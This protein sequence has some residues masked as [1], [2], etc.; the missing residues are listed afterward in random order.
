MKKSL[1]FLFA[2]TI[3]MTT[4]FS[5]V[6]GG[7]KAGLN[8]AN[9]MSSEDGWDTDMMTG[10]HIGGYL[11]L[12]VSES[13]SVQ[14]ELLFSTQGAKMTESDNG[15][16]Y[17]SK[18]KLNYLNIPVLAKVKL[19]EVFNIHAGPQF[20][21]LMSSKIKVEDIELDMKD[22]TNSVDVGIAAGLGVDLPMGLNFA[23]RYNLGISDIAK[24]NEGDKIKN[25]VFQ[26][27][28]GYTIF[29]K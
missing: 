2:L 4:A 11:D 7:L 10:F 17:E 27:S 24:D 22:D 14:P 26:L 6:S 16:D 21:I 8:L 18:F 3:S 29:G 20:G 25:G 15:V 12:A 28:V 5:Q 1:L 13:F 19:G 9:T 23:A